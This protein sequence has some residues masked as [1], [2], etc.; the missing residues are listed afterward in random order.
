MDEEDEPDSESDSESDFDFE[1]DDEAPS[2]E[3]QLTPLVLH[4]DHTLGPLY[5]KLKSSLERFSHDSKGNFLISH[6][7]L[8]KIKKFL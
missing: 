8:V 3:I 7:I 1:Y 5:V 4:K 2:T 6:K